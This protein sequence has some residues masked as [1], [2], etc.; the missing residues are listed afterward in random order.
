[1]TMEA[2]RE[3][4]A[5]PGPIESSRSHGPHLLIRQGAYLA[6]S[7]EHVIEELPEAARQ[8][9]ESSTGRAHDSRSKA[10]PSPT[11]QRLCDLL[12]ESVGMPL[13]LLIVKLGVPVSDAYGALL[14]LE[15]AGRV[16]QMPGDHYLLKM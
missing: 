6:A 15:L 13:D 2:N 3:V 14:E 11:G 1:M 7:A 16:R 10:P 8:Q 4:F 5:I 12:S 9:L